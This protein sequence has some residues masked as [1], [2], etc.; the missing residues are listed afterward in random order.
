[1]L[2]V[3]KLKS[4]TIFD[5]FGKQPLNSVQTCNHAANNVCCFVDTAISISSGELLIAALGRGCIP[6]VNTV[7][8]CNCSLHV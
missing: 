3:L 7:Y 2:I 1:M 4:E 8:I 6:N 5:L